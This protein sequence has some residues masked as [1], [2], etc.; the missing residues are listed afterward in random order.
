[1]A[2]ASA[3]KLRKSLQMSP[4]VR[5]TATAKK[6]SFDVKDFGFRFDDEQEALTLGFESP[7]AFED[8]TEI[9]QCTLSDYS[10]VMKAAADDDK[11]DKNST[12]Q[13][14]QVL[15]FILLF[16]RFPVAISRKKKK[17]I[18][19]SSPLFRPSFLL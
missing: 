19:E 13:H 10:Q 9:N 6:P 17:E 16:L 11:S 8:K 3:Q 4:D 5:E 18:E 12:T 15:F 14:R 1:M 7:S 2:A